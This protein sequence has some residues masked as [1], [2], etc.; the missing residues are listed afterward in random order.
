M[1]PASRPRRGAPGRPGVGSAP[2][3]GG[4]E[5]LGHRHQVALGHVGHQRV[6]QLAAPAQ[7]RVAARPAA[8]QLTLGE[9]QAVGGEH[10]QG[11]PVQAE[12]V[13][14]HRGA[15]LED[16]AHRAAAQDQVG[17]GRLGHRR[18]EVEPPLEPG[19]HLVRAAAL[20]AGRPRG[21]RARRWSLTSSAVRPA[22]VSA[23]APSRC[24]SST[25][26]AM[27]SIPAVRPTARAGAA[28]RRRD[29]GAAGAA[30]GAASAA[31]RALTPG[32]RRGARGLGNAG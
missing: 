27:S 4:P 16:V 22:A 13:L 17:D 29:Q 24:W 6:A 28:R 30:A 11:E 1:N 31:R 9:W 2:A 23:A 8:L 19:L 10:Q 12:R 21:G 14:E 3:A 32:A 18:R 25:P 7:H 15:P 26:P 20:D 5:R